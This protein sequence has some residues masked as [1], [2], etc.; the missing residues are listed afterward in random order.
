MLPKD[1]TELDLLL[2]DTFLQYIRRNNAGAIEQW[3]AYIAQH[4]EIQEKVAAAVAL[5]YNI[6]TSAAENDKA[7]QRTRLQEAVKATIAAPVHRINW[8]GYAWRAAAVVA[9]LGGLTVLWKMRQPTPAPVTYL[10]YS[11]EWGQRKMLTLPDGSAVLLNANTSVRI[12]SDYSHKHRHVELIKGAALFDVTGNTDDPFVVTSK[13]IRTTV[14]G[15]SFLVKSYP[16]EPQSSVS[17]L[18]GKVKVS[19]NNGRSSATTLSPGEQARWNEASRKMTKQSFDT[20]A[21]HT[22]RTGKL[23]FSNAS[24]REVVDQLENWYGIPFEIKGNLLNAKRFSG[25]FDND[26]LEK[27]LNIFCFTAGCDFQIQPDKVTIQF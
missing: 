19:E 24:V 14:L 8:R 21:L 16:Y 17:L 1:L 15:T 7:T 22:W 23:V 4:P 9:L 13:E 20:I 12:P 18:S 10:V 26:K 11:S 25:A 5:Y 6:N 3:E 27:V 2:D